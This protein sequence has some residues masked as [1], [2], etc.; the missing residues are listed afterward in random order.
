VGAKTANKMDLKLAEEMLSKGFDKKQIWDATGWFQGKDGQWR[1][2]I[3]DKNFLANYGKGKGV[4]GPTMSHSDLGKAY[5]LEELT[6]EITPSKVETGAYYRPDLINPGGH[7]NAAGPKNSIEEIMIHELM[8][9]V[10]QK[11]G[12]ARGGS[13]SQLKNLAL[14]MME[15]EF[16]G[17]TKTTKGRYEADQLAREA[18]NR[19]AGEVE[20]RNAEKRLKMSDKE[21]KEI[22]PWE[23]EDRPRSVQVIREQ[24]QNAEQRLQEYRGRPNE[25]QLIEIRIR[26]IEYDRRLSKVEGEPYPPNAELYALRQRLKELKK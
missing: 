7:I 13:F 6:H 3:S 5:D 12:F 19:I 1:F 17:Y 20:A 21:R 4:S 23:T 16:P 8:H 18:Y 14:E 24:P 11:E 25:Q 10:Q 9:A 2:E 22:P 26:Q 15:E